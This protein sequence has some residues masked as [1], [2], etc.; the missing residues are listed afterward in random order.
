MSWNY[1]VVMQ[2]ANGYKSLG[3]REIYYNEDDSIFAMSREDEAPL[4]D[5]IEDLRGDLEIMMEALDKPVLVE[6]DIE[7][8]DQEHNDTE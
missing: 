6:K 7:F 3:L 8:V 2:E 5:D 1:R 4:G